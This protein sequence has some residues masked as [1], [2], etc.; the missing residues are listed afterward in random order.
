M[1]YQTLK[2]QNKKQ[3]TTINFY[4]WIYGIWH[5]VEVHLDSK[6][7]P[8]LLPLHG[9]LF[10]AIITPAVEHWLEREIAQSV[11]HQELFQQP[12]TPW[13]DYLP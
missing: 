1:P 7:E 9:L 3:I 13:A 4:L 11:H 8:P 6:R 2:R 5:I 10:P 12:I